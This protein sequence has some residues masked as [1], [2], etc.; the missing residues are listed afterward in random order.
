MNSFE[1]INGLKGEVSVPSDKSITHRAFMFA[2]MSQGTSIVRIPLISRDTMSTK[3]AMQALGCNITEFED[4]FKVV[5]DGYQNFKEPFG[6]VDCGNS[7]TTARLYTGLVA[8]AQKFV[9]LTGDQSLSKRPMSR[10]IKPLTDMG[11][12][13]HSRDNDKFLPMTIIPAELQPTDII[14]ETKSAQVKSAVILAALQTEGTSSYTEKVQTRNHTEI[15]LESFGYNVQVDGLKITVPGK[16]E[17]KAAEII[18]PGDFSSA[19]FF[20]GMALMFENADITIKRVGLNPTRSGLLDVL[21]M[22]GVSYEKEV[23][24]TVGEPIGNIRIISSSF[25]G[26]K[27]DGPIIANIIDELPMIATLGL[28]A[29]EPVEIRG[30]EELRVKESDRIAAVAY[31]LKQLGAEFEEYEDGLKVY[32]LKELAENPELKSFD[33]HRIAMINIML[34]KRFGSQIKIDDIE[35]VDVSF[36]TFIKMMESLELS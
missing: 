32:P 20:I 36:P 10:V 31:N 22:F 34:G 27:I 8:A 28:F 21:E 30:A 5:S 25:K 3:A 19:A 12:R 35:C 13:I 26:C 4:G 23:T 29:D 16:A 17:L 11:A 33:D 24:S 18:V 2:G 1:K 7:G 9:V 15:M 6:I 14:A